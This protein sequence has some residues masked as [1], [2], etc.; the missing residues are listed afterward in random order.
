[1]YRDG[2]GNEA[3]ARL[4]GAAT[5]VGVG[6]D[7]AWQAVAAR[8]GTTTLD[9]ISNRLR[10]LDIILDIIGVGSLSGAEQATNTLLEPYRLSRITR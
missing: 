1:L 5:A 7:C 6:D 3:A 2:I 10:V 4:V 9:E 8:T